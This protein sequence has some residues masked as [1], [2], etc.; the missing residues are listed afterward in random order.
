MSRLG[1]ANSGISILQIVAYYAQGYVL[2]SGVNSDR[3]T[4][5]WGTT[6]DPANLVSI[7]GHLR[8]FRS[9]YHGC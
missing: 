7:K 6:T 1:P 3:I 2:G 4:Q 8:G 9:R 5:L